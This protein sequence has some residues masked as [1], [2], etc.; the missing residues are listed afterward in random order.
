MTIFIGN[1][2]HGNMHLG[3][4]EHPPI[5]RAGQFQAL[6]QAT[7]STMMGSSRGTGDSL[8]KK[9]DTFEAFT[10]ADIDTMVSKK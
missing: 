10:I 7:V 8:Q 1:N 4:T 5:A 3:I 2:G 9:F 6:A